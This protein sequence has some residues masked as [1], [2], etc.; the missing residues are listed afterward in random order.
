M[1]CV[2]AVG[3]AAHLT[4]AAATDPKPDPA[5][6]AVD[7]GSDSDS[8]FIVRGFSHQ[9]GF[10][11]RSKAEYFRTCNF[12]WAS[13]NFA[14]KL[15]V[16]P[17]QANQ[18]TMRTSMGTR[19][20]RFSSGDWEAVVRGTGE[21]CTVS[22]TIPEALAS[23]DEYVTLNCAALDPYRRGPGTRDKR[24]L[25][26]AIDWFRI[27]ATR[28]IDIKQVDLGVPGDE[29]ALVRGFHQREG[30]HRKAKFLPARTMT[31][32]WA[33]NEFALRLPAYPG[34]RNAVILRLFGWRRIVRFSCGSWSQTIYSTG[35]SQ[36]VHKLIVPA[37]VIG[38]QNEI[39]LR[40]KALTPVKP[41]PKRPDA[42]EL[43]AI[44][45]WI[46]VRPAKENEAVEQLESFEPVDPKTPVLQ[47]LRGVEARPMNA[48]LD[49]YMLQMR[50]GGVTA[51]TM[52]PMNGH[53]WACYPSRLANVHPRTNPDWIPSLTKALHDANIAV[54]AWACFNV[55]DLRK[56]EDYQP[57][58]KFPRWGMKFID[59]PSRGDKPAVG[60]CVVSSPYREHHAKF[61]AETAQFDIDAYFFDGFYLGGIPHPVAPGCVCEHCARRFRE[62]VGLELPKKVDWTDQAFKRWVRWR[63]EKL[64]ET[65]VY[66]RDAI[67]AVKPNT[68]VTMNT[69][70]W[71]F[72]TK[73][74]DTAIPLWR[75]PDFGVSQHAYSGRP[76]M[77]WLML[78]YKCRLSKDMNPDHGDIW[79]P[80]GRRYNRGDQERY[81]HAMRTFMLAGLSYGVVPWHG[82]HIDPL[83]AEMRVHKEVEKREP[84]FSR[85]ELT[86]V[87][88]WLS[89]NTHDFY[90]H[91][92]GTTNLMDY[93]DTVLGNWLVLTREHIPF[94]FV[95]DNLVEAG[96]LDDFKVIIAPNVAAMSETGAAQ[97]K[98]WVAN[99]GRLII[100][101]ETGTYDEW[102][103]KLDTPRLPHESGDLTHY[104]PQ[105]PGLDYV[106][107]RGRVAQL[108]AAINQT[109]LPIEIEAPPTLATTFMYSPDRKQLWIHLLNVSA[110]LPNS[111]TGFRGC[112][113]QAQYVKGAASDADVVI[114]DEPVEGK[115]EVLRDIAVRPNAWQ[116][117]AAKLAIA[118][119]EL[120]IGA[121]GSAVVSELDVHDVLVLRIE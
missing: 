46:R 13:N 92:P 76:D 68:P 94:Q 18:V 72:G 9:E 6:M 78:G 90:G 84:Y 45:D 47:R 56:I 23:A 79:R 74:W 102:G 33:M 44:I 66:F 95:F 119:R 70:M 63:N 93:R 36:P 17:R 31:F 67:N 20:L 50:E 30:P 7:V 64:I 121:D 82:G 103:N 32:R 99:G 62:D 71:P 25:A 43:M 24:E 110:Y 117:R 1:N 54:I 53:G 87:G 101:G 28:P 48:D 57:I 35:L 2:L 39:V 29:H 38:E 77:E 81:E 104:L 59:D 16:F 116:V 113:Q 89:Q 14:V 88:V 51:T 98:R 96:D 97:I 80:A 42:R 3:F 21:P 52:S 22:F 107:N 65:A 75:L 112:E 34:R 106:R 69:N 114:S 11:Q 109:P 58:K 100:T 73:D 15:P 26:A 41:S 108:L 91:L 105:D 4:Q 60:M 55:Q 10:N 83:P 118:N 61:L 8:Q 85:D 19:R 120:G 12:R 86:H 5:A 27:K 49:S 111:D 40:A 115:H 37:D